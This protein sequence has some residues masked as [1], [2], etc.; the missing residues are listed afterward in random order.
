MNSALF[1]PIPV[2]TARAVRAV[3]GS[4]N[5]YLTT[6]DHVNRLFDGIIL[7]DRAGR[8]QN[9]PQLLAMLSLITIFQYVE[10]LPDQL[11][12]DALTKRRD[13]KYALHLPMN[14]PG[15]EAS[16]FCEFR[17]WLMSNSTYQQEFQT[18]VVRWSEITDLSS[19]QLKAL[20]A[21]QVIG[22]VCQISRLTNIW[23]TIHRVMEALATGYPNWLLGHSLPHWYERYGSH[24][25]NLSLTAASSTNVNLAETI[26]ADGDYLLEAV[27]T[28]GETELTELE[29]IVALAD[30][31]RD[32]FDRLEGHLTWRKQACAGCTL[33]GLSPVPKAGTNQRAEEVK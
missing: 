4:G 10:T 22:V 8:F 2:E 30:M 14:Y 17:R 29:E 23:E 19:K 1:P 25:R 32:Q 6:G 27:L 20:E 9:P 11:A 5:P 24:R 28:S 33:L 12:A 3:F 16:L 21:S 26:G 7:V 15:L 13:W 18:L 31:W